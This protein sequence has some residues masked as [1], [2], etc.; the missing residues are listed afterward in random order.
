MVPESRTRPSDIFIS[1]AQEDRPAALRLAQPLEAAGWSVWWDRAIPAGRTFDE[2]IEDAIDRSKC[3][4]VLWSKSS[5]QSRWV[6]AE[7][8]EGA[9]RGVLVP[10]MIERV[11]IPL[12]FRRIHAADLVEW[13]G[14]RTPAFETLITDISSLIGGPDQESNAHVHVAEGTNAVEV[15]GHQARAESGRAGADKEQRWLQEVQSTRQEQG[16]RKAALRAMPPSGS[17]RFWGALV[18][19]AAGLA[20]CGVASLFV[21]QD[22]DDWRITILIV[23]CSWAI[24]GAITGNDRVGRATAL[25]FGLIATWLWT[26]FAAPDSRWGLARAVFVGAPLGAVLGAIAAALFRARRRPQ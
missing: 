20:I 14:S 6:R 8:E 2:V 15:G 16:L 25:T 1:Y 4:V 23:A 9:A 3:V 12:A 5:I 10:I 24:V 19:S 11:K 21:K 22:A 26:V 18:G 17:S 7:A 13:D